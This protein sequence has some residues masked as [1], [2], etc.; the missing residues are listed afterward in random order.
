MGAT[1]I[2]GK[3]KEEAVSEEAQ[4]IS[5]AKEKAKLMLE[6]AKAQVEVQKKNF[7]VAEERKGVEERE[8]MVRAARLNA[9]KLKWQSEE[10]L[11]A[12]VLEE[13]MKRMTEVKKEGFKGN[14][15]SNILAGLIKDAAMSIIAG[16][17]GTSTSTSTS[18][19]GSE[20]NVILSDE[21]ADASFVTPD[22]LNK[23]A[24][25]ISTGA[26]GVKVHLSLSDDRI[27]SA[28]G[29]IVRGKDEKIEVNNTFEQRLARFSTRLREE[30]VKNMLSR[31]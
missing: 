13:S 5:E 12:K 31:R 21:D 25:E 18:R 28:G 29:V 8:R 27:R 30:I 6:E 7:I 17:G 19:G 15:Y 20:L 2:V 22:M 4:I 26:G 11:I 1:E 3:I 10:G 9:R 24:D 16:S 14:S 23:I